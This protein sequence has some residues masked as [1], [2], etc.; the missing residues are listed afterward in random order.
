ME[1]KKVTLG[2]W[3]IRG[4]AETVRLVLEVTKTPYD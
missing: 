4:L 3:A 2:Y 1:K